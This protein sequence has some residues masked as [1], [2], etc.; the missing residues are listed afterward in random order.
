M[1]DEK[2][3]HA[4]PRFLISRVAHVVERIGLA[5]SGAMCGTFVAAYLERASIATFDSVGFIMS[6]ILIGIIGF[7]L[8]I[9][10][11]ELRV[12]HGSRPINRP[13]PRADPVELLSAIG[14]FLATVAALASVYAIVFDEV[15]QRVW[16]FLIGCWWLLGAIMQIG[17]GSIGRLR[18]ANKP[19][20]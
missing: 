13:V 2:D 3:Y 17:A 8:G 10:I 1:L 16:E 18:I 7:Y 6:M 20:G 14:T 15:P 5:M 12:S 19:A 4:D 11:P 9:D